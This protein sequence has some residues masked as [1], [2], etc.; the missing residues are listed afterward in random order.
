MELPLHILPLC[1]RSL[2]TGYLHRMGVLSRPTEVQKPELGATGT[3]GVYCVA[4]VTAIGNVIAR[5]TAAL[6]CSSTRSSWALF[7]DERVCVLC[8]CCC[9]YAGPG[10]WNEARC[11]TMTMLAGAVSHPAVGPDFAAPCAGKVQG[12][13]DFPAGFGGCDGEA[14]TAAGFGAVRSDPGALVVVCCRLCLQLQLWSVRRHM[15]SQAAWGHGC[16]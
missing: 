2:I 6:C 4:A 11:C 7:I 1:C 12:A 13:A 14:V 9:C 3:E 5:C 16:Q 10:S 8:C 15:A